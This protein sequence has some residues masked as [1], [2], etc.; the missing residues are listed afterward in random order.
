VGKPPLAPYPPDP[1][2]DAVP[3]TDVAELVD[4]TV[5]AVDWAN[6]SPPRG[7]NA[8]RVELRRCRLTGSQ[9]GGATMSDATFADCRLDLVNLRFAK[10]ERVVFRDCQMSECDFYEASL[11]D[12]LFERCRLREATFSSAVVQRVELRGCDIAGVE[13]VEALRSV[14]MPWNDVLENAPLFATALGIEII[15]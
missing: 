11:K 4:V 10:L 8:R 7:M 13:G 2:D 6:S 9:L 14:R 15:D 12:V 5:E 1:D 3:P